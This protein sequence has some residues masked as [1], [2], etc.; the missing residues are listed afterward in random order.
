MRRMELFFECSAPVPN[1]I[2]LPVPYYSQG[3]NPTYCAVA[4]IKMWAAYDGNMKTLSEIAAFVGVGVIGVEPD[5][6]VNGVG[7]FTAAEGYRAIKDEYAPGAYG[8][9]L[10]ATVIGIQNGFPSIIPTRFGSHAVICRGQEWHDDPNDRPVAERVYFH[11]PDERPNVD[12]TVANFMQYYFLPAYGKYWVILAYEDFLD[13]GIDGHID[14]IMAGGTYYG[15][16][17]VYDPLGMNP[18]PN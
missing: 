17:P 13:D 10:S 7:E 1:K 2:V 3:G 5:D 18:N 16:P 6:I 11:D 14:F 8:E 9:L 15:G 4:C 12:H